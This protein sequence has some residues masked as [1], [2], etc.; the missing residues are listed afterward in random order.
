[1]DNTILILYLLIRLFV[2]GLLQ[3][4]HLTKGAVSKRIWKGRLEFLIKI[5]VLRVRDFCQLSEL[6]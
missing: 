1:M 4:K 6:W 5:K 2:Y 3:L